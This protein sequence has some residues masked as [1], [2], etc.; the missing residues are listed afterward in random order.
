MQK[1]H[2]RTEPLTFG[3]LFMTTFLYLI[4]THPFHFVDTAARAWKEQSNSYHHYTV[5]NSPQYIEHCECP[6]MLV[7]CPPKVG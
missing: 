2:R 6:P 5:P 4:I 3:S 7:L 1:V